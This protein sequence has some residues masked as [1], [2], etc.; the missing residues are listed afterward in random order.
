MR[1][2]TL[3]QR[4]PDGPAPGLRALEAIN[5][6]GTRV[7]VHLNLHRGDF[8]IS[9]P[10]TGNVLRSCTDVTLAD[11]TFKVSETTRQRI[12][13]TGRRRVHAWAV[14]TLVAIDS[15]PSTEGTRIT[16]NPYRAPTFTTSDGTPVHNAD[17][18]AFVNR[19]GYVK[20]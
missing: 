16:Y 11:V 15:A 20:E 7:R 2:R 9:D 1:L 13:R 6:I 14:G 5:V 12:T 19:Y 17:T 4:G 18:V 10:R 8:S 3:S